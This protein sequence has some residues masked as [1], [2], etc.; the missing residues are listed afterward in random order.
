MHLEAEIEL[1]L[2]MN[3]EALIERVWD[4]FRGRGQVTQR[5]T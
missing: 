5:C 2:E 1:N 3:L 4:A